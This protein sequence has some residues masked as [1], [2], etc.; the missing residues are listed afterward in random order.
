MLL[1][2]TN[3]FGKKKYSGL[4][5][6]KL[7]NKTQTHFAKIE[8]KQIWDFLR[9]SSSFRIIPLALCPITTRLLRVVPVF[10]LQRYGIT[11]LMNFKLWVIFFP[12][13]IKRFCLSGESNCLVSSLS[14][15]MFATPF[16]VPENL[17]KTPPGCHHNPYQLCS[18]EDNWKN[19]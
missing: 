16:C 10:V 5:K 17:H 12:L 4:T 11:F 14:P 19:K 9:G 6:S 8:I 15:R 7:L 18:L 2:L 13:L 1:C 3:Q